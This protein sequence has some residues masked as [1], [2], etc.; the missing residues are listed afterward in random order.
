MSYLVE[1]PVGD[2]DGVPQTVAVEIDQV[3]EGL[4][5]VSRPG[6]VVARA[7]RSLG[8]M[9]AGI[10]PVA[11][12]FVQGLRGMVHAPDEIGIEFGLSLS[13]KAD[14]IITSTATQA[15]FKV[16]LKWRRPGVEAAAD[17][18]APPDQEK[19]NE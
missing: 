4:V 15:N 16:S 1:L 5:Q 14:V 17:E 7:G 2:M 11:E 9:V 3:D 6:E 10:R 12:H 13:A 18:P 19:P 8:E